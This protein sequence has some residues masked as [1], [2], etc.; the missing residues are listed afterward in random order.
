MHN[1]QHTKNLE[2]VRQLFGHQ[3]HRI[4]MHRITSHC[5]NKGSSITTVSLEATDAFTFA[6]ANHSRNL[7]NINIS[8]KNISRSVFFP[9]VCNR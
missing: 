9:R 7:A 3:T 8:C 5:G 6:F 2:N 1:N 4:A